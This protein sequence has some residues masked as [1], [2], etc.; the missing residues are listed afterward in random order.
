[1]TEKRGLILNTDFT[2]MIPTYFSGIWNLD[3]LASTSMFALP[4]ELLK[5]KQIRNQFRN[6]KH[7]AKER[8]RR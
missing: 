7:E 8:V 3:L 5:D 4:N 1:M 2:E 6:I